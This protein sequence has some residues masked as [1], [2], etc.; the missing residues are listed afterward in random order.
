MACPNL[1]D[2]LQE[3]ADGHAAHCEECRALLEAWAYVDATLGKGLAGIAAP[4][5]LALHARALAAREL[6]ASRP[7]LVPEILDLLGWAAVLAIAAILIP[8]YL[9]YL[10]SAVAAQF[11]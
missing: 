2:L 8:R 11:G 7:P 4:P 6:R 9:P 3:A 1:E 5:S 10:I